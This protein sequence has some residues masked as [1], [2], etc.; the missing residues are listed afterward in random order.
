MGVCSWEG[1]QHK[2]S[3]LPS[4]KHSTPPDDLRRHTSQSPFSKV[5]IR[6]NHPHRT[7]FISSNVPAIRTVDEED[8]DAFLDGVICVGDV[9][10]HLVGEL[11]ILTGN[12]D[13]LPGNIPQ[14]Q[15]CTWR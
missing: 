13:Q 3:R 2:P 5:L 10:F 7:S 4:S 15:S 1:T 9:A 8:Q 12:F 6:L 11:L 14:S